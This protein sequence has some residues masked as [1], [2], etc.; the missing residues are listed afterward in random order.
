MKK[1]R[2]QYYGGDADI[3]CP[4]CGA[5]RY[6]IPPSN[7]TFVEQT[8]YIG[9]STR[10]LVRAHV[11]IGPPLIL[12]PFEIVE[13]GAFGRKPG[14]RWRVCPRVCT[15]FAPRPL[16]T[17]SDAEAHL[18]QWAEAHVSSVLE[19]FAKGHRGV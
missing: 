9:A 18:K 16:L 15:L 2:G 7:G 3:I 1:K 4:T 6:R 12:H 14:Y 5:P 10:Y 19:S 11:D 8:T 13:I 17:F